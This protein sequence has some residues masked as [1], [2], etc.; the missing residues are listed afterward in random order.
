MVLC[1]K[2]TQVIILGHLNLYILKAL[3]FLSY[4]V[5]SHGTKILME[6]S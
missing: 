2:A 3:I 5:L 4:M 6:E 1:Q